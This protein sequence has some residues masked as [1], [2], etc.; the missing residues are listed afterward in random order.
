MVRSH[1]LDPFETPCSVVVCPLTGNSTSASYFVVGTAY[2]HEEEAEPH[3]GRILVF[4]VMGIYGERKLRFV[5]EKEV[6]GAVYYLN[7]FNGKMLAGVNSKAPL[8]KWSEYT[9]NEKELVS[10][11]GHYAHTLVLY[12]ESRGDFIVVVDW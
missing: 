7:A 8:Y 11:C 3:Q 10:E 9:D 1:R 5:A 4:D 6:K 12:M 2:V